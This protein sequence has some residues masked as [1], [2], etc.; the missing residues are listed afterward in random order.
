MAEEGQR[1][2]S[3]RL[4]EGLFIRANKRPTNRNMVRNGKSFR[5]WQRHGLSPPPTPPP[6]QPPPSAAQWPC[7]FKSPPPS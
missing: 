2:G 6:P 3:S 5:K 1:N 4:R 7:Q